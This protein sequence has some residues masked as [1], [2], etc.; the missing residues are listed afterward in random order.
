MA[1]PPTAAIAPV[2]PQHVD[3]QFITLDRVDGLSRL[4]VE[5]SYVNLEESDAF[6]VIPLRV[7]L[8]GQYVTPQGLGGFG[9][10][11]VTYITSDEEDESAIGNL[12]AGAI[13]AANLGSFEGVGRASVLLPT[14]GDEIAD[15]FTNLLGATSRLT[16]F[17]H[18]APDSTWLR[19]SGSPVVRSGNVV[20]R[21]D[22]GV[23]LAVLTEDDADIDP[24]A[25]FNVGLGFVQGQSQISAELVT[26]LLFGEEDNERVN[27]LGVSY[28]GTFGTYA[29]YAGLFWFLGEDNNDLSNFS[30]T[31][32]LSSQLGS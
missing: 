27:S 24:I 8:Y 12:E 10:L 23:D 7:G 6:D 4:G 30:L 14:A 1:P 32:G 25:H 21:G 26:L 28:R 11:N 19:L 18:A 16:D 20:F 22:V 17:A 2:G 31:F 15:V 5:L 3:A 29:P 9:A 13:Y